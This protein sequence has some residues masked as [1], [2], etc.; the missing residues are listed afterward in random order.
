MNDFLPEGYREPPSQ[1]IS[2]EKGENKIRILTSP[3]IGWVAWTEKDGKPFPV[4]IRRKE[5][6]NFAPSDTPKLFWYMLV[7]NYRE[8]IV[9]IWDLS[10]STIRKSILSLA[11]NEKWGSP[12]EYDLI[13]IKEGQ[14][15]GTKYKVMANPKEELTEE[16]KEALDNCKLE[17]KNIFNSDYVMKQ[18]ESISDLKYKESGSIDDVEL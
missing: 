10:K 16:I 8:E 1:T 17:Y 18:G 7:W 9:Q 2:F 12:K 13:I 11:E 6:F 14:G 4:R 3:T 5:T 15:M